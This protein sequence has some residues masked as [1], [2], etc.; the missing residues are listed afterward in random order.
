ML[1]AA[2]LGGSVLFDA[3]WEEVFARESGWTGGD[4]STSIDLGDGRVL[5]LFGDTWIGRVDDG[6]HAGGSGIVRNTAATHP[7]GLGPPAPEDAVFFAG[8][9]DGKGRPTSW[10]RPDAGTEEEPTGI[11]DGGWLWP[12]T[13]LVAPAADGSP[14]LALFWRHMDSRPEEGD[15]GIWDFTTVGGVL[16]IVDDPGQPVEEWRPRQARLPQSVGAHEAGLGRP[17]V[18]WGAAVAMWRKPRP[19]P[20]DSVYVYGLRERGDGRKDLVVA[21]VAAGDLEDPGKWEY[22]GGAGWSPSPSSARPVAEDVGAEL[23][24]DWMRMGGRPMLVMV[25]HAP[26]LSPEIQVRFAEYPEG[27]WTEPVEA[28]RAPG[29]AVGGARFA[30]GA[31]GHGA[32]S[33]PQE[34]LV[35]YTVNSTDF[36]E[37]AG[38][39][40]IYR[41]RFIRLDLFSVLE[42][43]GLTGRG[44]G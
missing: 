36:W 16:A 9:R 11:R 18:A 35:S 34:Y 3:G 37:M 26:M 32:L 19:S 31:K 30:Y 10:L 5:W 29:V 38:D 17:E 12:L 42:G 40:S 8:P 39:A 41:P 2:S 43:I 6:R 21:R 24:V 4:G 7:L 1:L 28:F 15:H 14:R 20:L 13:G 25:H 27:P 33:E 22:H 44:V 23:T